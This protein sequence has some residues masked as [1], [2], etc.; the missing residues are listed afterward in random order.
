VTRTR[1]W[2]RDKALLRAAIAEHGTISAAALAFGIPRT[3]VA[4]WA[5]HHGVRSAHPRAVHLVTTPTGVRQGCTYIIG[6]PDGDLYKIGRTGGDPADRLAT[7]QTGSPVTLHLV[8]VLPHPRWEDVLHHHFREQRRQGEWFE[9]SQSDVE[10][11]KKWRS[12]Q[13]SRSG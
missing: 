4:H 9:L 12:T 6:T 7:L 5:A 13:C 8:A 11:I 1:Y 3:T 2:Y 10:H